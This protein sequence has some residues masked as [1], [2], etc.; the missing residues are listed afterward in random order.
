MVCAFIDAAAAIDSVDGHRTTVVILG[1]AHLRGARISH[2]GDHA[3]S[4]CHALAV[5][6]LAA[7][8]QCPGLHVG[9]ITSIDAAA[10]IDSVDVLRTAVVILGT[11][12]SRGAR[13]RHGGDQANSTCHALAVTTLAA[14]LQYPG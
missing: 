12:H 5:T 2:G 9:E 13:I 3:N 6:T 1:T 10:A 14:R 11:A 8:L 4:T 7:R